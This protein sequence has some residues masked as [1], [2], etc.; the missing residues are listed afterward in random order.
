MLV[1]DIL[2]ALHVLFSQMLQFA[3]KC[4]EFNVIVKA[5]LSYFF[6]HSVLQSQRISVLLSYFD[7][8]DFCVCVLK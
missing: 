4:F 1:R 2:D 3:A 6:F 5:F 8:T 7:C